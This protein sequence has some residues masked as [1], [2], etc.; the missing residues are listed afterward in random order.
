MGMVIEII[1]C[2]KVS[3]TS[4]TISIA[5]KSDDNFIDGCLHEISRLRRES[6]FITHEDFDVHNVFSENYSQICIQMIQ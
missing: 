1:F 4:I 3:S 2:V 6:I 5:S